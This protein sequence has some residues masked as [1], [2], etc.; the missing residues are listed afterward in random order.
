VPA[1]QV[2][3]RGLAAAVGADDAGKPAGRKVQVKAVKNDFARMG[4]TDP[5]KG[6][7]H[8]QEAPPTGLALAEQVT[9]KWAADQRR[10]DPDRDLMGQ[11]GPGHRIGAQQQDG[12]AE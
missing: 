1:D 12:P 10:E 8:G 6:K 4:E 5:G 11:H 2:Q 7:P 3:Q 9:E